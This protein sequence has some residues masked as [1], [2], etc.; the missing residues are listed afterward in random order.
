VTPA[1]F[2]TLRFMKGKELHQ[3]KDRPAEW[4][5]HSLNLYKEQSSCDWYGWFLF[6]CP[7]IP[8]AV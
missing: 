3:K 5:R 7:L 2:I 6:L 8:T 1:M 4:C